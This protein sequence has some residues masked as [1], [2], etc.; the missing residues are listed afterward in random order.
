MILFMHHFKIQRNKNIMYAYFLLLYTH[1]THFRK[2][3]LKQYKKKQTKKK[4]T[5]WL[6]NTISIVIQKEVWLSFCLFII[7]FFNF[8]RPASNTRTVFIMALLRK[9]SHKISL[10][11][12]F[13]FIFLESL[14]RNNILSVYIFR[15]RIQH[16]ALQSAPFLI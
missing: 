8:F 10:S 12:V 7:F 1:K 5:L 13:S 9:K 6:F 4:S 16:N 2:N 11:N 15:V 3:I 14:T